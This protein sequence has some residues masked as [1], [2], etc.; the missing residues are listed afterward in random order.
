M[1]RRPLFSWPAWW[2]SSSR[3]WGGSDNVSALDRLERA[4]IPAVERFGWQPPEVESRG[5]LRL[6]GLSGAVPRAVATVIAHPE[7]VSQLLFAPDG[8]T[9]ISSGGNREVKFWNISP[10]GPSERARIT[11]G[12]SLSLTRDGKTLLTGP[13]PIETW[14]LAGAK[15]R[16]GRAL[17][18]LR[19][20]SG[21]AAISPDGRTVA[22]ADFSHVLRVWDLDANGFRERPLRG[23]QY[24]GVSALTF[25]P[26]GKRV[27]I[28][29]RDH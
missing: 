15:P 29:C 2:R 4:A 13:E 25:F 16:A 10:R 1:A 26:D 20:E 11:A 6:W 7:R 18:A 14:D 24:V 17:P 12:P 19:N 23:E 8:R 28:G 3:R 5:A 22:G 21:P 27:A 9:L